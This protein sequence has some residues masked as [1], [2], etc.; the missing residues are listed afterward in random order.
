M[1]AQAVQ[2]RQLLEEVV[3]VLMLNTWIAKE[4]CKSTV[5]QVVL[6]EGWVV[7]ALL[8]RAVRGVAGQVRAEELR[9]AL[10]VL[11]VQQ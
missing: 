6:V 5:A 11:L 7:L 3:E 10:A 1:E 9:E 4:V 2:Q 8:E